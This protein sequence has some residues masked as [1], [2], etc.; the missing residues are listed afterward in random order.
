MY[1]AV[2]DGAVDLISAFSSDG[3]I[4]ADDLVV[5]SDPKR[6]IPRYDAVLLIAPRRADDA[7]FR[8]ALQPLIGAIDIVA[9]RQANQMVD[10]ARDKRTPAEAARFL[11]ARA[12]LR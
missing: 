1:Q 7:V 12:G 8:R 9:M 4:A 5:L 10:R 3:R 11:A 2:V 6:V